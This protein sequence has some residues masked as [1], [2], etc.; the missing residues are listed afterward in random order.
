MTSP[1]ES[2]ILSEKL[3][4]PKSHADDYRISF[5]SMLVPIP[6][7]DTPQPSSKI[8]SVNLNHRRSSFFRIHALETRNSREKSSK[9]TSK[10]LNAKKAAQYNFGTNRNNFDKNRTQR[11]YFTS[12]SVECSMRSTLKKSTHSSDKYVDNFLK[13]NI[14]LNNKFPEYAYNPRK[15]T[16]NE[17]N[18]LTGFSNFKD[19]TKTGNV[20]VTTSRSHPRPPAKN[21]I[22]ANVQI[23]NSLIEEINNE[24][25]KLKM[26]L[27]NYSEMNRQLNE[28]V[29]RL[30][31]D[32]NKLIS[33]QKDLE[34]LLKIKATENKT[35]FE[36]ILGLESEKMAAGF[37][38]DRITEFCRRE[39]LKEDLNNKWMNVLKERD[40]RIDSL[41]N[42]I[43]LLKKD[44]Q[45][46][47]QE[48]SNKI[49]SEFVRFRIRLD[50]DDYKKPSE[51][52]QQ[53][54]RRID[55]QIQF[56]NAE[57]NPIERDSFFSRES[58]SKRKVFSFAE[59][60]NTIN[61]NLNLVKADERSTFNGNMR[62][63][64][65][66]NPFFQTP[67]KEYSKKE[68]EL[69]P[70]PNQIYACE[71]DFSGAN[72]QTFCPK[73]TENRNQNQYRFIQGNEG[74]GISNKENC[75][76]YQK[77]TC[78]GPEYSI[79][80]AHNCSIENG[81]SKTISLRPNFG[82]NDQYIKESEKRLSA[83][84]QY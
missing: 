60:T 25:D 65:D 36:T 63:T 1:L 61:Q 12:G 29:N 43:E 64:L 68:C 8:I 2:I 51:R 72:G 35:H 59:E 56:K 62:L 42:E 16:R 34:E 11:E 38:I 84:I 39:N 74:H 40:F 24:N 19:E 79:K 46:S 52:Y 73:S 81:L 7:L 53:E 17:T 22:P 80:D 47:I 15:L 23:E 77:Y 5:L 49:K 33:R 30:E 14:S 83:Y 71:S 82:R 50:D 20:I 10:N 13:N 26:N 3:V 9:Q 75:R 58:G 37:E 48:V 55:H 31:S 41:Q 57:N 6:K 76:E 27:Q 18:K 67:V 44:M 32:K 54:P 66:E 69:F 45:V 70:P 78:L 28:R 4:F 21:Y